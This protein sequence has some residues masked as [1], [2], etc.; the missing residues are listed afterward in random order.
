MNQ[1]LSSGSNWISLCLF[2]FWKSVSPFYQPE[3]PSPPLTESLFPRKDPIISTWS[4]QPQI[5]WA[6]L[7]LLHL[8]PHDPRGKVKMR[9]ST[10]SPFAA[11][12][13]RTP[14][15][16]NPFILLIHLIHFCKPLEVPAAAFPD[17]K[18]S[19]S[20]SSLAIAIPCVTSMAV[21]AHHD[22]REKHSRVCNAQ[23][24]SPVTCLASQS[25][26]H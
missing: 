2:L 11:P 23:S 17:E 18:T 25:H 4:T 20:L 9:N 6:H 12:D 19:A 16:W 3:S 14:S 15:A 24:L 21:R 13:H 10:G 1:S 7:Q 8:R 22:Y 26:Q 5:F